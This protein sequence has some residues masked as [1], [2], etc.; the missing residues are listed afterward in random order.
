MS[1]ND[2][3]D[4]P[5]DKDRKVK[6]R[7]ITAVIFL[8]LNVLCIGVA[9]FFSL[10][11]IE[12]IMFSGAALGLLSLTL[13]I[14]ALVMKKY[15]LLIPALSGLGMVIYVF[16]FIAWN[17]LSP[18]EARQPVPALILYMGLAYLIPFVIALWKE[19]RLA[20]SLRE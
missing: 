13:L 15:Y 7:S 18:S 14:L 5:I 2:L 3:L 4:L 11:E 20:G 16:L 1:E 8:I 10:G 19:L 17:E 6:T 9:Y 12:S